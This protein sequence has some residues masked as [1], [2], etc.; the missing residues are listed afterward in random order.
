MRPKLYIANY[1]SEMPKTLHSLRVNGVPHVYRNSAGA[2]E[3]T[4]GPFWM[5][6]GC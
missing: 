5:G 4:W 2:W 6:L 3:A 1:W